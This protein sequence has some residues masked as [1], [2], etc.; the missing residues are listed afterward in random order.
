MA[1]TVF[2]ISSIQTEKPSFLN[3]S[4]KA[5]MRNIKVIAFSIYIFGNLKIFLIIY[6]F[7]IINFEKDFKNLESWHLGVFDKKEHI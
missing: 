2:N 7:P 6:C 1:S 5:K 3:I 4:T